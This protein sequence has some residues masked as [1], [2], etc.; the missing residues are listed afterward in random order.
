LELVVIHSGV[1]HS[2][3]GGEYNQRRA[4]CEEACRVLGVK[5]LRNLSVSELPQ[6]SK[7]LSD[8]FLRRA[9]HVITENARVLAAVQAL[10]SGDA[11][12]LGQLFYESHKSMRDDYQVSVPEID[13][14]VTIASKH[15]AVFG[16]RLTGGGFGGSIVVIT[17][18][19]QGHEVSEKIL[20][21]YDL[22]S[23]R[24]GLAL[25]A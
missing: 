9:R 23:G 11:K 1:S 12:T 17:Q 3:A 10:E 25:V 19:G 6:I 14:L 20:A 16:A 5:S 21:E 8:P 18:P 2:L 22:A 24:K 13:L 4:Q 7:T 15:P